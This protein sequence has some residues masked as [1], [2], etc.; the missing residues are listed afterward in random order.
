MVDGKPVG[1]VTV[2]ESERIAEELQEKAETLKRKKAIQGK[3]DPVQPRDFT[4]A[5]P[6]EIPLIPSPATGEPGSLTAPRPFNMMFETYVGA[7]R[8]ESAVSYLR[9]ETAQ[10]MFVDFKNVVD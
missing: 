9:P 3:L 1:Y 10:G 6:E 5:K 7:L 2:L 8:D 4:E